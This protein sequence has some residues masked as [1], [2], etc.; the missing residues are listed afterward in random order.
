[1]RR[2]FQ[3]ETSRHAATG[4]TELIRLAANAENLALRAFNRLAHDREISGPL[5]AD[6][7]LGLPEFYTPKYS[8]KGFLLL[9]LSAKLPSLLFKDAV[10]P[11]YG[12]DLRHYRNDRELSGTTLDN[13]QWRGEKLARF[14]IYDDVKFFGIVTECEQNNTSHLRK[15]TRINTPEHSGPTSHL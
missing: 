4:H 11:V 12:Q 13:Y 10:D 15:G 9:V 7:L 3:K 14:S 1:M 8:M 2:A 6:T 5:A